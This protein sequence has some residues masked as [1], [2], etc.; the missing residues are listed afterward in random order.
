MQLITQ[1]CVTVIL[2]ESLILYNCSWLKI[3]PNYILNTRAHDVGTE[4]EISTGARNL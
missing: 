3:L 1:V 4:F 2:I